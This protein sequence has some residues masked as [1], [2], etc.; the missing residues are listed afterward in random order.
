MTVQIK[1]LDELDRKMR[2]LAGSKIADETL[3]VYAK[4]VEEDVKPY[5]PESEANQPPTPYYKRGTGTITAKGVRKTSEDMMRKWSVNASSSK[6]S[7]ENRASYSAWVQGREEDQQVGYHRQRGWKSA[8]KRA[9]EML[10]R[11]QGI[12][13]TLFKR[14]WH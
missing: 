2:R 8:Q 3:K 4:A 5:P 11:V 12:F 9:E 10:D 6:V 14:E 1:G 7:L 13:N